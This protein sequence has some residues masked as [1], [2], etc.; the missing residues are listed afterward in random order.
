MM[1]IDQKMEKK[2]NTI[3]EQKCEKLG[4]ISFF[5]LIYFIIYDLIK[6]QTFNELNE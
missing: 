6:N 2:S 3:Y 4:N 5:S 1:F